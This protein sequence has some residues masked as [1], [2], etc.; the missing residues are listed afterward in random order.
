MVTGSVYKT[1]SFSRNIALGVFGGPEKERE[2]CLGET[3]CVHSIV[4]FALA[5]SV[6]SMGATM[7]VSTLH[8]PFCFG[9]SAVI[10][11]SVDFDAGSFLHFA[12]STLRPAAGGSDSRP[13][14][15]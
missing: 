3:V 12:C 1:F 8:G 13:L 2:F 9:V 4:A 11:A 10:P 14:L 15:Q 6:V 7:V 5:A